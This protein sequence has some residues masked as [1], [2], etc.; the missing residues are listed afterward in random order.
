MKKIIV[1]TDF[2]KAAQIAV[3][4]AADIARKSKSEL[5]MLHVVE[6]ATGSSFNVEGQM[7]TTDESWE[8]RIF[9]AKL[10][11]KAKKQLEKATEDPKLAGIKIRPELRIGSP[12]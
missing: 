1:P 11:E 7:S 4:V 3:D 8:N 10:I 6:E 2:S 9:T 12:F 5:I